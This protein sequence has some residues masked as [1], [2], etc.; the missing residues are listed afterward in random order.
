MQ[1]DIEAFFNRVGLHVS[2]YN[3]GEFSIYCP[4][5]D[6]DNASLFVNPA[7]G[8]Y[9]CFGGCVKGSNGIGSLLKKLGDGIDTQFMLQFPDYIVPEE[10]EEEQDVKIDIN[11]D[12]LPLTEVNSYL[13]RR[14]ITEKTIKAFNIK[15]HLGYDALI[16]P[17]NDRQGNLVGYIR[18]NLNSNPKYL[19]AKG[20]DIGRLVFPY[21][22]FEPKD[23]QVVV[24]EGLFDAI[25][26]HQEGFT[27]VVSTIG[28]EIKRKQLNILMEYAREVVLC[29][30]RDKE[31][32]RLAEKN[33][34]LLRRFGVPVGF[35][36][37]SGASKDLAE[38]IHLDEM[39]VTPDFLLE[40][41][42][43]SISSF[44]GVK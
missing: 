16:V 28:G 44:L 12:N 31:G 3:R 35:T 11:I 33:L 21:E 41:G 30:D 29:P 9:N 25:R 42:Q 38:S 2:R 24:V 6:D 7:K 14:R 8:L 22:K 40:F 36:R 10:E 23:G 39:P 13:K 32:V 4:W 37:P 18:R 15:Y 17:I 5:H 19:N 1:N 27:N 34:R 20:M 43:K 26:A